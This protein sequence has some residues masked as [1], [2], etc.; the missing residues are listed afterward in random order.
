M[1]KTIAR[2]PCS[3]CNSTKSLCTWLDDS[4]K[5]ITKCK[6]P[7]CKGGVVVSNRTEQNTSYTNLADIQT[8]YKDI[9]ERGLSKATCEKLGISVGKLGNQEFYRYEYKETPK[10]RVLPKE[11]CWPKGKGAG[12][13]MAFLDNARNFQ[14]PIILT[15]G[16]DDAASCVEVGFQAA[17][18]DS[19]AGSAKDNIERDL[20]L[21]TRYPEIW[22]A[23]DNDKAGVAAT[24]EAMKLLPLDKVKL[25]DF[26]MYKDANQALLNGDLYHILTNNVKEYVPDG[27]IFGNQL[28]WGNIW[29]QPEE[30]FRWPWKELNSMIKGI[31]KGNFYML[32]A[33][34]SIGKSSILR[35]LVF[36]LRK[37]YASIR[38][39][40]FFLEES[41]IDSPLSYVALE[42]NIPIGELKLNRDL[43]STE[44]RKRIEKDLFPDDKSC[45]TDEQYDVDS[46]KLI[47]HIKYLATVKK[48][49]VI[50]LDHISM[51]IASTSSKEGERREIDILC[52]NLAK[53]SK[54]YNIAII[55][56]CHLNDPEGKFNWDEGAVPG[57]Y[58]GRGSKALSQKPDV[59]IAASRNMKDPFSCDQM[60]L[61]VL[62]NRWFSKLGKADT[63]IYLEKTGRLV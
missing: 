20:H 52:K 8:E 12:V 39:A 6:N 37:E 48:Y 17:S 59:V 26:D 9:P 11:F 51:V 38:I 44:E 27:L 46:P 47:E 58:N 16:E 40:N 25:V 61:H 49:D 13:Q 33:G 62:K 1:S 29:D 28:N 15:E 4:G 23:F 54:Q 45:F 24:Q 19:G 36:S 5:E 22:L 21:L 41:V 2:S 53:L 34:T 10:I 14:E 7:G 31:H 57:L 35:E 50:V 60:H 3:T 43:V 63:L 42:K 30:G 18:L 56:A 32:F 55:S